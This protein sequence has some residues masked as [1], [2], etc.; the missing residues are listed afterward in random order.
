LVTD[1]LRRL[2][3]VWARCRNPEPKARELAHLWIW[4]SRGQATVLLPIRQVRLDLWT[5]VA[6]RVSR[7]KGCSLRLSRK[8]TPNSKKIEDDASQLNSIGS[9]KP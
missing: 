4:T 7:A 8:R 9:S 3:G 6:G 2:A 5:A 1:K